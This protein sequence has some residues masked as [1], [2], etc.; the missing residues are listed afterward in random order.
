LAANSVSIKPGDVVAIVH[1]PA[2][3]IVTKANTYSRKTGATGN[4]NLDL[5]AKLRS[6]GVVV[7]V[8]DQALHGNGFASSEV[9]QGVRVD[10]SA[11]TTITT[12]QLRGWALMPD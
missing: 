1:G 9:A 11:M 8:C 2:T 7:A 5:I 6:A 4:P 10:V 3:A 12:L